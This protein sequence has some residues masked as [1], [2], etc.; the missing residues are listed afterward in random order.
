LRCA[1]AARSPQT[2]RQRALRRA[3]PKVRQID[4]FRLVTTLGPLDAG[5][6]RLGPQLKISV[7]N[8]VSASSCAFHFPKRRHLFANHFSKAVQYGSDALRHNSVH[9]GSR[10]RW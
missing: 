2:A 5:L 7:R 8:R 9:L 1:A 3:P 4:D 10:E 6:G